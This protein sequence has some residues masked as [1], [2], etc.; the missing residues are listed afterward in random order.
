[1]SEK[2]ITKKVVKQSAKGNKITQVAGNATIINI[3]IDSEISSAAEFLRKAKPVEAINLLERLWSREMTPRQKYR[4]KANIGHAYDQLRKYEDA[5]RYWLEAAQYEPDYEEALARKA[6]AYLYQGNISEARKIAHKVLTKYPE[7]IWAR[8][9]WIKTFPDGTSIEDI[10]KEIPKHQKNDVEIL[11]ALASVASNKE[12]WERAEQ[13]LTKAL[14]VTAENPI[15]K[16]NLGTLLL[17]KIEIWKYALIEKQPTSDEKMLIDKAIEYITSACDEWKR[18]NKFPQL[19]NA[20]LILASAYRAIGKNIEAENII[21]ASYELD[22]SNEL[23]ACEY[24]ALLANKGD[25][26]TAINI[27]A[28]LVIKTKDLTVIDL[29]IRLLSNR[30]N[31]NDRKNA[32]ELLKVHIEE[33]KIAIPI[34]RFDYLKQ[35]ALLCVE[36]EGMEKTIGYFEK[37][38]PDLLSD[39]SNKIL[40]ASIY[41]LG[42]DRDKAT[43]IA[44]GLCQSG[45]ELEWHEKRNLALLLQTLGQWEHALNIWQDIVSTNYLSQDSNNF[46]ETARRTD[47]AEVI[48]KYCEQLRKNQIWDD[49]IINLELEYREKYNDNDNAIKI[50]QEYLP[51]CHDENNAKMARLRLSC[52]GMKTHRYELLEKDRDKLPDVSKIIPINGRIVAQVLSY[53]SKP[54]EAV[55]YA[56]ELWRL[57]PDDENANLAFI[58]I[59]L[60]IGPKVELPEYDIVQPGVA[61][62]YEDVVTKIKTWHIIENSPLGKIENSRNEFSKE[63]YISKNIVGKKKGES[64][65]LVNN[66]LEERKAIIIEISSKYL[67]RYSRCLDE[68]PLKFPECTSLMG[69]TSFNSDGTINLEPMKR[70]GQRDEKNIEKIILLYNN[71]LIPIYM[72]GKFK[73]VSE[74]IT[75]NYLCARPELRIKTCFGALE[76]W[77]YAVNVA[78]SSKEIV[79]DLTALITLLF[80][81]DDFWTRINR[82]LIIT[83][84][85]YNRLKNI[86]AVQEDYINEGGWLSFEKGNLIF[87][88]KDIKQLISEQ[89]KA[90]R[91][92]ELVGKYCR[93]ES[94]INLTKLPVDKRKLLIDVIGQANAETIVLANKINAVLWTDDL[95]LACIANPEFGCKRIWSQVVAN[96]FGKEKTAELNINLYRHG[97]VFTKID[98]NDLILALEKSKWQVNE[99]PLKELIPIFS[100][101]SIS[102]G[103][104][105]RLLANFIKYIWQNTTDFTAHQITLSIL[106]EF[107][108]RPSGI[109]LIKAFP[110]DLVFG[111]DCINAN[112]VKDIIDNWLR[113]NNID[114]WY[115]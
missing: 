26:T 92:I 62:L 44:I 98:L 28:P 94:G 39:S 77:N 64:F 27:L 105:T 2:K 56:Y 32:L 109:L 42:K 89:E 115:L 111:L 14:Q 12:D 54:I 75:M 8:S 11:W 90:K 36:I 58:G 110:A 23:S 96:L 101:S 24:S 87:T 81:E 71:Q 86:E 108:K 63:H 22:N 93:I 46:L 1:M 34:F 17:K 83:E 19:V 4:V 21:R 78:N 31:P 67:Y 100:D 10:E 112:R 9:V 52:L 107:S 49:K 13:Y 40:K 69:F 85:T 20:K 30:N 84:G 61:V 51:C 53:G 60:P 113:I 97:Y 70:L 45:K 5:A 99:S 72:L 50:I 48:F 76:E 74:F 25:I 91:Y 35:T 38:S 65:C 103:S 37:L 114:N 29:Y 7:N 33:L 106:N 88:Q 82:N 73:G 55:D 104:I 43:E 79:L 68:F 6:M 3:D 59:I 18:Q 41:Y 16:E 57:H 95:A 47:N 15:I 80:M 102:L 66:E